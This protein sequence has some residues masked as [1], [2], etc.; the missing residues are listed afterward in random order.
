MEEL[1]EGLFKVAIRALGIIIRALV[2]MIWE[3]C[4]EVVGWYAGWLVCR[5]ASFGRLP[6]ES[7]TEY[8]QASR[9]TGGV[10]CI[11]GL[12]SLVGIGAVI[13]Q[14]LQSA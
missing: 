8:E 5:V 11:V 10:V 4:F 9:F 12:L 7:I 3:L 2:W 1:A 14:S 13:A 6:R